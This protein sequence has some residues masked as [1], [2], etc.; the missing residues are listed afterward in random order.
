MVPIRRLRFNGFGT[1]GLYE[2]YHWKDLYSQEALTETEARLRSGFGGADVAST[3]FTGLSAYSAIRPSLARSL[4]KCRCSPIPENP[5]TAYFQNLL[6]IL[7]EA[8]F[9]TGRDKAVF[10]T[11]Y[12]LGNQT[13]AM[14]WASENGKMTIEMTPGGKW[15]QSLDVYGTNSILSESQADRLW[16]IASKKFA[17]AAS[18]KVTVFSSGTFKNAE[19][20]FYGLELPL[21]KNNPK[22][23]PRITYRGY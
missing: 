14:A 16:Q 8:D 2:G 1:V 6:D 15:L 20:V 21:L 7:D 13:K 11:G 18:G 9:T 12:K 19:S 17:S 3:A 10:W 5:P 4:A 22:V 23:N